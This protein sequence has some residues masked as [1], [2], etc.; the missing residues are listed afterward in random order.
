[1]RV[2][3]LFDPP[4]VASLEPA[5]TESEARTL[6][7]RV[8]G[9]VTAPEAVVTVESAS[10]GSTTIADGQ[11][12]S[13]SDTRYTS[14]TVLTAYG[15]HSAE[16]STDRLD[17]AGLA[18]AVRMA[19]SLAQREHLVEDPP[20]DPP[21]PAGKQN[22][23]LWHAPTLAM[24]DP[25]TRV[26]VALRVRDAVARGGEIS[27]GV[28][29]MSAR[30]TAVLAS[31]GHFEYGRTSTATCTVSARTRD[32]TG[33]GWA[34]WIGEDWGRVDPVGLAGQAADLARRTQRAVAI[35]PG[36]Y[37][38]VL[39]PLAMA[40]L[41]GAIAS[42]GLDARSAEEGRSAFAR[43]GGKTAVGETVFD[44]RVTLSADP[45]D[46]EGGFLPFAVSGRAVEQ[47]RA[48]TWVHG[49]VLETLAWDAAYARVR[50]R[51]PVA[52]AGAL[53]MGGGGLTTAELVSSVARGLYV[54]RFDQVDLVSLRTFVLTGLTRDGTFLIE[55]GAITRPV[56]NLRFQ[57]S[58]MR[59]LRALEGLGVAERVPKGG[60]PLVM[61]G[62]V[63]RDFHFTALSERV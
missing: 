50:G 41:V 43:P 55:R 8:L 13:S 47:F 45:M 16:V 58:P 63:V 37:T 9:L 4:S 51:R 1:V 24:L 48:E 20:P 2:R 61:P 15:R 17:D 27:A 35:E 3:S 23:A 31:G 14:V 12:G 33:A 36:V 21:G 44:E 59:V 11:L 18:A 40:S 25:A 26:D 42:W 46:L 32:G 22:A 28:V 29:G 57:D 49:G 5:L 62:G 6:A 19:E 54:T 52:N 53:R 10:T 38:V 56:R 34:G 39:S 30:S 7:Q 60:P